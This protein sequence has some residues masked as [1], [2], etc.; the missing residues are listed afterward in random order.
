LLF[1]FGPLIA[2]TLG[3]VPGWI[4]GGADLPKDVLL[5]WSKWCGTRNFLFALDDLPEKK[6]FATLTAPMHFAFMDDDPWIARAGVE[7]LAAQYT[8]AT[9]RTVERMTRETCGNR[10]VGHIGFFRSE[11]RDTLWPK[12]LAWLDGG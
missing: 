9:S 5:E 4:N 3:Y 11:F 8:N 12:A 1:V 7:H 6:Y 10:P 2:R